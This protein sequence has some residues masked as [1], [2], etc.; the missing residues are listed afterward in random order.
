MNRIELM[1]RIKEFALAHSRE[2][3]AVA[4]TAGQWQDI[5]KWGDFQ[6]QRPEQLFG[7][8]VLGLDSPVFYLG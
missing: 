3:E 1:D 2:P 8:T 6:G 7:L 5:K 4:F